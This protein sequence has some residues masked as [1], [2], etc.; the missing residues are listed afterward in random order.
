MKK[1]HPVRGVIPIA[2]AFAIVLSLILLAI[3]GVFWSK[4]PLSA[5]RLKR[6]HAINY[7][8][9]AL[10]EAVHR[11]HTNYV[12]GDGYTWDADT[13]AGGSPAPTPTILVDGVIPV[14]IDVTSEETPPGGGVWRNKVSAKVDYTKIST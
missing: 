5:S 7:A 13:W 4:A 10:H 12:D 8:E 9:A 14:T 3:T 6:F 2:L 11:F 1:N